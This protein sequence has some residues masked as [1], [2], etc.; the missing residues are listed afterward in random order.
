MNLRA[1]QEAY[2]DSERQNYS[3]DF[4]EPQCVLLKK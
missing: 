1:H 4:S 2:R 3:T